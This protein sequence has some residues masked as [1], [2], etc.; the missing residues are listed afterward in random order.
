MSID[1]QEIFKTFGEALIYAIKF[2]GFSQASFSREWDKDPGM[3]NKYVKNERMPR[4]ET[5]K[6]MEQVLTVKIQETKEGWMVI[7]DPDAQRAVDSV[8][9][10]INVYKARSPERGEIPELLELRDM[11]ERDINDL[12]KKSRDS[13]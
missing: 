8:R 11:I 9:A 6:E 13:D 7:T 4:P 1:R 3:V 2:K 12:V 10:L 5:V